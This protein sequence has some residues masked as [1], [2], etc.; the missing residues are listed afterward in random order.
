[1]PR[2]IVKEDLPTLSRVAYERIREEIL[3]GTL[4][5]GQPLRLEMLRDRYGLSFSPLREALNQLQAERLVVLNSKRGFRVAP[6]SLE[7]MW[8]ALNTRILIEGEAMR[9]SVAH[10]DDDWEGAVVSSFHALEKS[11]QRLSEGHVDE[12]ELIN[13]DI[14]H[15]TFHKTLLAACPS[16]LLLQLS[17][18][19]YA[20]T[21]RY[22]R[23][24]LTTQVPETVNGVDPDND[25][26]EIMMAA[27]ARDAEQAAT[28][29]G[30]HLRGTGRFIETAHSR[31]AQKALA[32]A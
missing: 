19:L 21:E 5:A 22:R 20:Q 8:D 16:P 27:L 9:Q 14:R 24:L 31:K 26:R 7:D 1:M 10:G 28:L 18:T 30:K 23:P 11:R 12:A 15:Q 6:D 2:G 29:L 25:H 32:M 13:L 3:S 4:E 17:V